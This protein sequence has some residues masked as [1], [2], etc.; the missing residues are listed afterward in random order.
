MH[1]Y[2]IVNL[3][4]YRGRS[5]GWFGL[6]SKT[7]KMLFLVFLVLSMTQAI[8]GTA[9]FFCPITLT[10]VFVMGGIENNAMDAK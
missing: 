10:R 3:H 8:H 6:L 7:A 9:N 4:T 5:S 1:D 2:K